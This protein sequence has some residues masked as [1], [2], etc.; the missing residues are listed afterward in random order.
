MALVVWA[1]AIAGAAELSTVVAH[2]IHKSPT[3]TSV[4][5][6]GTGTG[7]S[8]TQTVTGT[9]NDVSFDASKVKSTDPKSLFHAANFARV[10][11]LV[12]SHYGAGAKLD[13]V[14]IY[15]GYASFT[16][17]KGGSEINVYINAVGAFEP[18]TGGNPGP[19]PLF[20]LSQLRANVPATLARRIAA[21]G[22]VPAS[23]LRY[24]VADIDLVNARLRWLVYPDQGNRVEYF[25]AN[26]ATGPLL[27]YLANSST[28]LQ[29]VGR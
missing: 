22:H 1:A 13:S 15:P 24:M 23:A 19:T 10:L 3:A 28:G 18:S 20:R 26:G 2:S 25:R 16:V 6:S 27:E 4:N 17:V 8:T 5:I 14:A 29:P 9:N 21:E 12:R 7:S 11:A